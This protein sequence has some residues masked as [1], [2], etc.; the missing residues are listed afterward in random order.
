MDRRVREWFRES[1]GRVIEFK[2]MKRRRLLQSLAALPA[3]QAIPLS[4]QTAAPSPAA[5]T[6]KVTVTGPDAVAQS[7]CHYFTVE[8][9][10][11]LENLGDLFMP[12]MGERPGAKE[13]ETAAFLEFLISQSPADRQELYRSG[14]DR[15][16][17]E[18]N[19]L[20]GKPFGGIGGEQAAAILK[21]VTI[22]WTYNGPAD[23]FARFLIAAKEDFLRATANSRSYAL[24][25]NTRGSGG[26]NYYWLPI[27]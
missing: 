18:A 9:R 8:Q 20:Y 13:A 4:A 1:K 15:L 7:T 22:P 26:S 23:P 10:A 2:P 6:F 24:S 11:A 25:G 21:P 27:E 14:L 5:D 17:S 12:K 19:R 16:N 3:I